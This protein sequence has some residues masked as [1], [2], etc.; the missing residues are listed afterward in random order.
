MRYRVNINIMIRRL[1][2]NIFLLLQV[3]VTS[4][5]STETPALAVG[6]DD[7]STG[8]NLYLTYH[9]ELSHKWQVYGGIKYFLNSRNYKNVHS[10]ATPFFKEFYSSKPIEKAGLKLGLQRLVW[11][12]DRR[13]NL[14][15][16]YE[17][18][19]TRATIYSGTK[20]WFSSNH[21]FEEGAA[22]TITAWENTIGL[23]ANIRINNN[24]DFRSQAGIGF[25]LFYNSRRADWLERT[26]NNFAFTRMFSFSLMYRLRSPEH[27]LDITA[28]LL[29]A[30]RSLALSF[31]NIQTGRNLN[32]TYHHALNEHHSIYGGI[33]VLINSH[34]FDDHTRMGD[35]YYFKQFRAEGMSQHLGIKAG[36]EYGLS[37]PRSNLYVFGFFD[38]QL[39]KATVRNLVQLVEFN[40][41]INRSTS[42]L[43]H[44][45]QVIYRAPSSIDHGPSYRYY[46]PVTAI[47]NYIGLGARMGLTSRLQ[48]CIQAGVGCNLYSGP[49]R[50]DPYYIY[51]QDMSFKQ[52]KDIPFDAPASELSKMFSLGI[53]YALCR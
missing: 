50:Y 16:F 13:L 53:D 6:Y 25:N 24:I 41:G 39:S 11:Q 47:E 48:L 21:Y 36:Y 38:L 31:D 46:G 43:G 40:S 15:A 7:V 52:M 49:A 33:K 1:L 37:I 45:G 35:A 42:P 23:A 19:R 32:I 51:Y 3:S 14:S 18:Q 29:P 27:P 26:A 2:L 34:L 17:L 28:P 30:R 20:Y 5:Q 22:S 10:V 9:R 44:V 12:Q 4:G 8:R